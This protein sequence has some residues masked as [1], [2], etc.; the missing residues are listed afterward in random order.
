[1]ID[2]FVRRIRAMDMI[3]LRNTE[4]HMHRSVEEAASD[5]SRQYFQD[6][7]DSVRRELRARAEGQPQQRPGIRPHF[8]NCPTC[9]GRPVL[10]ATDGGGYVEKCFDCG[11]VNG[12]HKPDQ[13]Y[14]NQRSLQ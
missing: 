8:L 11:A 13:K 2:E 5:R 7:L 6:R 10:S 3:A 1:M 4:W 9:G 14:L 12:F